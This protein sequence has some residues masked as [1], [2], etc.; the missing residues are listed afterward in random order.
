MTENQSRE[1]CSYVFDPES[2][3][4]NHSRECPLDTNW[5]CPHRIYSEDHDR[6]VFHLTHE[7]RSGVGTEEYQ[8]EFE[9]AIQQGGRQKKEFIGISVSKIDLQRTII[10][11]NDKYPIKIICSEIN[12]LLLSKAEIRQSILVLSSEL[13]NLT[14]ENAV[15]TTQSDFRI[16]DSVI[17]DEVDFA[18]STFHECYLNHSKFLGNVDFNHVQFSEAHLY[19]STF[20]SNLNMTWT[21]CEGRFH[22]T[23][24]L[25]KSNSDFSRSR[26]KKDTRFIRSEFEEEASFN[27]I[28]CSAVSFSDTVFNNGA[29]FSQ[30]TFTE[31][32]NFTPQ[33]Y[34][35]LTGSKFE[36]AEFESDALFHSVEFTDSTNF[37]D[38]VFNGKVVFN[39]SEFSG[40]ADFSK[41]R[42][43][44]GVQLANIQ[45]LRQVDFDFTHINGT[46]LLNDAIFSS[47][48][49]FQDSRFDR[50]F[51]DGTKFHQ[52][53]N[54]D[55]SEIENIV[56]DLEPVDKQILISL[57][58]AKLG[59]GRINH[60]DENYAIFDLTRATVGYFD[61]LGHS[62][63]NVFDPLQFNETTFDGFDFKRYRQE[64]EDLDWSFTDPKVEE[65]RLED[66]VFSSQEWLEDAGQAIIPGSL[67]EMPEQEGLH[68]DLIDPNEYRET[69]Y[70]KAKNGATQV[71]DS[72]AAS[73]FF[74]KEMKFRRQRHKAE[75]I[76]L[77]PVLSI[78]SSPKSVKILRDSFRHPH[79]PRHAIKP[80]LRWLMNFVL[81]ISSG[82]GE[83]LRYVI[84]WSLTIILSG[85]LLYPI[86]Q[87]GGIQKINTDGFT[88]ISYDWSE[89]GSAFSTPPKYLEMAINLTEVWQTSFYFSVVSFTTLGSGRYQPGGWANELIAS[90]QSFLGAFLIALFVYSLGKQVAR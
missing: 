19:D 63:D 42:F 86:P 53:P 55:R 60:P 84:G 28:Q 44:N 27:H 4:E 50:V 69:T 75:L 3:Q 87:L 57:V 13:G 6:C 8:S 64:L 16:L 61:L 47:K 51:L 67:F 49:S 39:K 2:W 45:F 35:K 1:T 62:V 23:N 29:D 89:F 32:V 21:V 24:C 14:A 46:M 76:A 15:F 77:M 43:G 18:R 20:E 82:Y 59:G 7:E 22:V 5:E 30:A 40:K 52:G 38:V 83:R 26:F 78:I 80:G 41:A 31:T 73:E 10:K 25:I 56:F 9:Y 79:H 70:Q 72:K 71:G 12:S 81:E 74:I 85:M 37:R 17:S 34:T 65:S 11:S 54:F 68:P 48:A 88:I 90:F 58:H 36:G 33:N 66:T